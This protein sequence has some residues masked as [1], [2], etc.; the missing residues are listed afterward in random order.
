MK[1][2]MLT[3][4]LACGVATSILATAVQAEETVTLKMLSYNEAIDETMMQEFMDANPGITVEYE[5]V[6]AADAPTKTMALMTSGDL[7]DV[8]IAQS[9]VY[10]DLVKEGMIM[11]LADAF[12]TPTYEGEG[13][14]RESY[15]ESLLTNCEGILTK[16]IS[17]LDS[18]SYGAP[19]S[20]TTVAVL[21]DQT[22]YD[23]LG[24][25]V[26]TNWDEF[27]ANLDVIKEA[28]YAP[29]TVQNNTCLDWFP[30][31]FWDQYCRE[32]IEVEGKNFEDGSMTF[33]TESVKEALVQYK[34]LFDAGYFPESYLTDTLDTVQQ[35]FI[36][37]KVAQVMVTPDKIQYLLDNAPEGMKLAS[38]ALPGINGLPS[39]SLGGSS[40]IVVADAE[41]EHPEEAITLMKYLTSKTNFMTNKK[42]QLVTSGLKGV[43]RETEYADIA[44]GYEE[45]AVGGFIPETFVPTNITNEINTTFRGELVQDYLLG[46]IDL[47][48]VCDTLQD[49]YDE[50]LETLE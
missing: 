20:M 46:N 30:R 3:V 47:D 39:R 6:A 41:T 37:G 28:G 23:T 4:L 42:L 33:Q 19:F 43:E 26:P 9:S 12:E 5:Y 21:Y 15:E 2:K 29:I 32:E 50:Y 38:Y 16:A 44:K 18:Y 40:V 36:Q 22:I 10:I 49:M 11:D 14:W 13:T 7:P 24:I 48:T 45:A 31:F 25:A 35:L 8:F 1:R 17:G 34:N 27:V